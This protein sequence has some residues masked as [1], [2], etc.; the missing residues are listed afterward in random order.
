MGCITR[1]NYR[2]NLPKALSN[3]DL[4]HQP[5]SFIAERAWKDLKILTNFG[6]R[7]TGAYSNEI[8]AVDFLKR[9]I[10]Y[11][12]QMANRNQKIELDVQVRDEN[13][14]NQFPLYLNFYFFFIFHR[15]LAE[16][17]GPGLNLTV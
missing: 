7:P 8:L 17:I 3:N 16:P 13:I 12:K 4:L 14:V 9:E 2:E 5:N 10:S 11:I 15:W 1:Y 6:P